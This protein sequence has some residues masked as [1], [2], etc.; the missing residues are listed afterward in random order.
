MA[1]SLDYS[2]GPA[3]KPP[4]KTGASTWFGGLARV[5]FRGLRLGLVGRTIFWTI[6][7]GVLMAG[8]ISYFM[9]SAAVRTLVATQLR[10]LD[11]A[12]DRAAFSLNAR[13]EFALRQT[14]LAYLMSADLSAPDAGL[15]AQG[16]PALSRA[17]ATLTALLATWPDFYQARIIGLAD[18][19]LEL[20]RISREADGTILRAADGD[21]QQKGSRGYFQ[22]IAQQRPGQLYVSP[23]DLNRERGAIEV[24]L[25]PTVRTGMLIANAAGQPQA[26]VVLNTELSNYFR[27]VATAIGSENL[28]FVTNAS[29]DY[30]MAPDDTR[31]FAFEFGRHERLQEDVPELRAW[32]ASDLDTFSGAV[33]MGETAYYASARRVHFDPTDPKRYAIIAALSPQVDLLTAVVH[34]RNGVLLLASALI[35]CGVVFAIVMARAVAGPIA[36]MTDAATQI[37]AGRRAIDLTA[38]KQQPD[39]T[40]ELARALDAM[41]REIGLREDQL[42]AQADELARSNR[43]LGQFAYIASHDLQEPLRMVGSYLD[44]LK[45]RYNDKL[46]DD[47]REFIGYAVDGAQRMKQLINDLLGYSRAGNNPLKIEPVDT[48]I[49][50]S[51]VVRMLRPMI[52]ETGAEVTA[53]GLPKLDAD[54]GQLERLFANLVENGLKYRAAAPPRIRI[55]AERDR[56]GWR[57]AVSDNGIGIDPR[58]REKV[59]EIFKRLQSRTESSGTGI[60][61]AVCKRVV[62]RH[63]GT[64]FV[65]ANPDGGSV[66]VFTIPDRKRTDV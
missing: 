17:T 8:T 56:S 44:L 35:V 64:I 52:E 15:L 21:L 23:F 26:M 24:P 61:L 50:V 49:V 7:L 58:F 53:E 51:G 42:V 12:T 60:G 16:T 20:V 6:V 54:A 10:A 30:L 41:N 5:P 29:G 57:F 63:G 18:G 43:E 38:E 13:I 31:T 46:D 59:F 4:M 47:A 36:R 66:F 2:P 9:Y 39:E 33:K 22:A 55:S 40:G 37:A 34:E 19:G 28:A 32:F 45:R 1:A 11:T 3:E 65:E 27:A 48:G 14:R 25:R 62:E